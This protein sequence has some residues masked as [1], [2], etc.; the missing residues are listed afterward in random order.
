[1]IPLYAGYHHSSGHDGGG[2][3]HACIQGMIING[4]EYRI[5]GSDDW[6]RPRPNIFPIEKNSVIKFAQD[7]FCT[8]VNSFYGQP[9]WT[10]YYID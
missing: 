6:G 5:S 7:P 1:M 10:L 4:K 8:R 3:D 2:S 9:Y